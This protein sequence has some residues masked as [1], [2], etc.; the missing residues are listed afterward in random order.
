[1][2]SEIDKLLKIY[3]TFP[4]TSATA[5]E[6][7]FSALRRVKTLLRTTMTHSRLNNLFLLYIHTAKT[8]GLDL[9]AITRESV[10]VNSR[11]MRYFGK[12]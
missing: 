6:C 11:R 1:M 12:F 10:A 3:F 5:D 9:E 2:L 4:V 7:S 8:D